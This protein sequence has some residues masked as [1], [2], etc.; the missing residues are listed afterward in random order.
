[1]PWVLL[2]LPGVGS[3]WL[4]LIPTRCRSFLYCKRTALFEVRMPCDT[5]LFTFDYAL[6]HGS[7]FEF[8]VGLIRP[9]RSERVAEGWLRQA[10]AVSAGNRRLS[11]AMTRP[12]LYP[13]WRYEYWKQIVLKTF[14]SKWVETR[15]TPL[16]TKITE[17]AYWMTIWG[18]MCAVELPL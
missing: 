4:H 18:F 10:D 3:R 1:M 9:Q 16:K 13:I 17:V 2:L 12:A 14:C 6:T 7:Q 11:R 8:A 5:R 15:L